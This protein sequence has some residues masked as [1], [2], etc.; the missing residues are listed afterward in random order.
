MLTCRFRKWQAVLRL[1]CAK[2]PSRLAVAVAQFGKNALML[3][4]EVIGERGGIE[5][6]GGGDAGFPCGVEDV[7]IV[8]IAITAAAPV[9]AKAI[10]IGGAAECALLLRWR[11]LL[12]LA[13]DEEAEAKPPEPHKV[14]PAEFLVA[15]A[16]TPS[17]ALSSARVKAATRMLATTPATKDGA[18]KRPRPGG[19]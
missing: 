18:S 10:E 4:Y 15:H 6:A 9:G 3:P 5:A 1:Q 19:A 13:G 8:V 2:P 11:E 14:Q 12:A 17:M 16:I 7:E